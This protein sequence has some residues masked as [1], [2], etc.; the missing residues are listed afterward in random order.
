MSSKK[1]VIIMGAAGRDFH[2]FNEF[3]R[4]NEDYEVVAFTA[5]QI[6]GIGDRIYPPELSGPL[7]PDG[8]KIY[9]EEML[10]ELIEKY[11][12]EQCILAYSDLPYEVVGHKIA[13]VN[14]LGPDMRLMGPKTTMIKSKKPVIAVCAVRT[15]CG[16]SQ[17]SRR[18]NQILVDMGLKPVNIRHPMPYDPDLTSQIAQR[19]ETLEDMDK[20]RCTIEEREEYEPMI[21][22]GV[23]LYAGVDYGKI[24]EQAEQEADV[25]TWDGGNNDFPFYEPDLLI[26][27]AD[28]H[29]PGHEI[30]YY[31]GE[32]NV[33]M[34]DVVIINKVETADYEDI[35]EV[36]ENIMMVNPD[37]TIIDAASPLTIENMETIKGKRVIVVED[38]PTVTHGEMPYGAGYIAARKAGA[39]IV[40]PRPF[41]VGSIKATFEK[42]THL[43]DVL[44]A[45]GY[46]KKQMAELEETINKSDVDAIVIG[47]P[48]DLKNVI[49][50]KK[51]S[52]RVRYDLQEIGRPN[53]EDILKDFVEKH[54]LK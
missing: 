53:L 17:T 16:K 48:I 22:M 26:V 44:P 14:K 40:D 46:G 20:Y 52:V 12:V 24:L 15:G 30:M 35:E 50:I 42:Y 11:D 2:N 4:D 54:N 33:R 37:A 29:R 9:P 18:V 13:W 23:I 38:G 8:I 34:A 31:P 1:K 5:E 19:Y 32:T 27:I 7:Y 36:R 51:P 10:P 25:I 21:N 28:P 41:A 47:T 43:E 6:P 45:M 39:I 3:F 49:N